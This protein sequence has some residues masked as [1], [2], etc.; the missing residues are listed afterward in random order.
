MFAVV[1]VVF[2]A[3]GARFVQLQLLRH[4]KYHGIALDN[5]TRTVRISAT[6]GTITDAHGAVLAT[7]EP[8]YS[9][10]VTPQWMGETQTDL[11]CEL[12]GLKSEACDGFRERLRGFEG[13][14]RTHQI[15]MFEDINRDQVAALETHARDLSGVDVVLRPRRTYPFASLGGHAIGYMN[16][17]SAQDVTR[18]AYYRAG[19][20]LGRTGVERA[21][22]RLLRGTRG[23]RQVRVYRRRSPSSELS[24]GTVWSSLLLNY[25]SPRAGADLRLTLDMK[26]MRI[27]DLAFRS[28]PAGGAVAVDVNT[29]RVRALYSKPAYDPNLMG[30]RLSHGD[31]KK[32]TE[33]PF[34]PLIDRTVYESYFPGSTF[35]VVTLLAALEAGIVD[36]KQKYHCPGHLE[37]GS[38][39]LRCTG[40]H[41]DVDLREAIVRSCN[42]YTWRLA[43]QLGLDRLRS[44]ADR[45]GF[46]SRTGI[47]INSESKGFL[48]TKKW[49][50]ERFGQFRIGFTLNAS[51][52]QGNTRSTLLQLAMAYAAIANGG[53]LLEPRLVDMVTEK[54][55]TILRTAA[56]Q[57][58]RRIHMDPAHLGALRAGLVGVVYDRNGT[59]FDSR[60]ERGVTFAGKTGTA[61]VSRQNRGTEREEFL[62]RDHAWF[63]GYAPAEQPEIALVVLVEHGGAGGKRAAPIAS[64]IFKEYFSDEAQ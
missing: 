33:N 50:E 19:D 11:F 31:Y 1:L 63:A 40:V 23:M 58:R 3:I 9:V 36:T 6:R 27:M 37:I 52:G 44:Y 57:L 38:Q 45:L 18:D 51:I 28:H 39:R 46:G 4:G 42:V 20:M 34:R 17:V 16:E 55:G 13:R 24:G 47:G 21:E 10:Y 62:S 64:R 35:K 41:G 2:C 61:Q 53:Y 30:G 8:S 29:G 60:I 26:L 25:Q 14:R 15:R 56:K 49:Y 5:T 59:A 32:L 48:A 22:E 7:N 54:D 12:M 43:E